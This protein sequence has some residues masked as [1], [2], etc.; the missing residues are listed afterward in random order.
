MSDILLTVLVC[1]GMVLLWVVLY[2]SNRFVIKEHTVTDGRIKRRVR[3][4]VIADLH[5]KRYGRRN[6]RLLAAIRKQQPDAVLIAGDVLT[7]SPGEKLEPAVELLEE[8]VKEYPI[9]YGNGNHEH[10]LKLYPETYGDMG[11]RYAREL[12]RLGISPLV[13][14]K[15]LLEDCGLA[16]YGA[17]LD[18]RFYKRFK[19]QRMP[20]EYLAQLLGKPDK[21]FYSVLLAHNPDYFPAYAEWG[22]DLVLSG[23]VHG[24]VARVPFW[25]RGIVAPSLRLFPRY[26]GGVFR[27][28][29]ATMIVSRGLGMHTIPFRAFNPAELWTVTFEPDEAQKGAQKGTDILS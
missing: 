14:E 9:Y 22:A 20:E 4:V 21:H 26:D 11:E 12:K 15:C 7:A 29:G 10:R 27:E 19:T 13:N 2:D 5:N 18:K 16:V 23:H 3:A 1:L 17:E 6:E 25:G 28:R 24:G 8:L